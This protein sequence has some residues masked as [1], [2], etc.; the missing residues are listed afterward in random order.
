VVDETRGHARRR[1]VTRRTRIV[2]EP[3][4]G[5]TQALVLPPDVPAYFDPPT[6]RLAGFNTLADA[7]EVRLTEIEQKRAAVARRRREEEEI[8]RFLLRVA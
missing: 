1:R 3:S 7:L 6:D 5:P 8:V 2:E 4:S